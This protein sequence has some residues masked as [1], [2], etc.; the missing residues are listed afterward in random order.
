M[1]DKF[2]DLIVG[3]CTLVEM[4]CVIALAGIALKRNNDCYEAQVELADAKLNLTL[5]ELKN[6][7]KDLEIR[8]LK[9]KLEEVC[10]PNEES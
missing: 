4:G 6:V 1:N 7:D 3:V 8:A 10:G 9:T 5:A 2:K